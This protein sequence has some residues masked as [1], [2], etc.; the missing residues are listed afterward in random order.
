MVGEKLKLFWFRGV[1]EVGLKSVGNRVSLH[2]LVAEQLI[3]LFFFFIS[4]FIFQFSS[5]VVMEFTK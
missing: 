4:P 5:N 1:R 3:T 2:L